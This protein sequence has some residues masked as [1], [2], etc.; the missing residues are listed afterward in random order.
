MLLV[1]NPKNKTIKQCILL[2]NTEE[3][4]EKAKK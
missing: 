2:N 1:P 4:I 3:K